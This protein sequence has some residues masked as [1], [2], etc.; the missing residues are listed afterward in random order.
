MSTSYTE[1]LGA[2]DVLGAQASGSSTTLNS[3]DYS[4]STGFTYDSSKIEFTNGAAALKNQYA[5]DVLAAATFDSTMNFLYSKNGGTTAYNAITGGTAI[6]SNKLKLSTTGD[7]IRWAAFNNAPTGGKGTIRFRITPHYT[8]T[9]AS[10]Q[11]FYQHMAQIGVTQNWC[12]IQHGADGNLILYVYNG[13][14]AAKATLS[15]AWSPTANTEYEIEGNYNTNGTHALYVDGSRVATNT[16]TSTAD[17]RD[18]LISIII[19]GEHLNDPGTYSPNFSIQ[20]LMIFSEQQNTGATRTTGYSV[21]TTKYLTTD[22]TIT[23]TTGVAASSLESFNAVTYASGSDSV[24]FHILVGAQARYWNGSAWAN[25]DA[26]LSQSNTAAEI[27]TNAS[28]LE[29]GTYKVVAVLHSADG[30][31]TPSIASVTFETT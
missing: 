3:L 18:S 14:N 6:V 9:P 24:K 19:L 1:N 15:Y 5:T 31:T 22:P 4:S 11:I 25:S 10:N 13:A 29:A 28:S 23:L 7:D 27:N 8:G 30:S 21:P 20:D 2:R 16:S 12:L 17:I 26:S